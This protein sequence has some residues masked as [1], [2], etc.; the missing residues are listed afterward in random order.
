MSKFSFPPPRVTDP[1]RFGRVAVLLGGTS[2]EAEVSRDS[3]RNVLDALRAR[4]IDATAVDGIPAL[5][6]ALVQRRFDR[7]FN[8]LHGHKGGGE[9][10]VVQGLMEAFGMPYTGSPV[11]GSALSMDKVRT[12]QVWLSLGLPTPRYV[13]LL[14]GDDVHAAARE[15]G[16]PVIVKPANEGSSVGVTRVF[17][18]SDLDAAVELAI[19]YDGELLME[20]LIE[21]DELTVGI[22]GGVALPSIRIVPKGQWY[23]YHAKYV[24]EDTQ[25]LCPGLEGDDESEIRRIALAAFQA[26]GCR[27]WGRVDVMRDRASG[28]FY[29]LE[30]NTAP[31]MTSHSLVPKAAGQAGLDFQ[32]LCWRI[33]EQTLPEVVG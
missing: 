10:G 11:L 17:Q 19:R 15:L 6:E 21:G 14:K 20:Q 2:S 4:G 27:G 33:L 24:A 16:L 13:R 1:A 9:D 32:E 31:G 25:Y 7:V 29:L 26:A 18:D 12:K 28:R 30:V 8:I 3:G 23:D 22:L 5:A